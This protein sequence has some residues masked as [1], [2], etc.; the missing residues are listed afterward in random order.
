LSA[1]FEFTHEDNQSDQARLAHALRNQETGYE[2]YQSW[3]SD[4]FPRMIA[5]TFQHPTPYFD[6]SHAVNSANNG[7]YGD[8]VMNELIPL[9]EEEFR[10][11]REPYARVL[12]GG[13]TGGWMALAL[14]VYHPEFFGGTWPLYPDSIDF[15]RLVL[16][17]L[18][19]DENAFVARDHDVASRDHR[20]PGQTWPTAERPFRR[21]VEGQV[22]VTMREFNRLENVFASH[23]R[24]GLQLH[25]W[26]SV[27]GPVGED[28]YPRP[29]WDPET[30]VIDREV[31]HY[32]RDNG[33]DLSHYIQTNWPTI[34]PD[35]VGKLHIAVGDM[36]NYYLNGAVYLL[37]DFLE[38]TKDP[39]YAGSFTYGRPKQG[40][41]WQPWTH[42]ELLR[43]MAD[44]ITRHA[45]AGEDTSSWKY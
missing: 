4:D 21:S 43:I 29:A 25:P 9:V 14:Q 16:T 41:F 8:A 5:V 6:D 34:G 26:W 17:N 24:S 40:H 20:L 38:G 32:M 22:M 35:L 30:G 18:Y 37:E 28:G 3:I 42:A 27:Y 31:A 36:D 7:P 23:S 44:H 39:Y 13:S 2:F 11:I 10:I 12:T 15:R 1:P 33:Y 45:P 19:E